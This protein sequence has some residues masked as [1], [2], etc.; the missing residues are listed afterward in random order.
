MFGS[1]VGINKERFKETET[2][3]TAKQMQTCHDSAFSLEMPRKRS[4]GRIL[5][6]FTWKCWGRAHGVSKPPLNMFR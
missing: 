4:V 6:T 1:R 5:I 3:T 2:E